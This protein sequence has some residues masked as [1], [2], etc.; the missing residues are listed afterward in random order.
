MS[1]HEYIELRDMIN[2]QNAMLKLL[3]PD[4]ASVSYVAKATGKSR[5]A[6]RQYLFN[7]FEPEEDYWNE[8]GLIMMSQKTAVALLM[9][10]AK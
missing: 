4:K 10:G 2:Q 8:G 6:I 5:Q 1:S 3:I 9:R 7:H